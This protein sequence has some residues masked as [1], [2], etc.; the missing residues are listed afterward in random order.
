M[1]LSLKPTRLPAE[2][3]LA[4]RIDLAN[5]KFALGQNFQHHFTDCPGGTDDSDIECTTPLD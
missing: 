3:S 2:R 4:K 5:R 1:F